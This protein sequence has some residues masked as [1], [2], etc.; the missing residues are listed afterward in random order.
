MQVTNNPQLRS[1]LSWISRKS[2]PRR[3]VGFS[4]PESEIESDEKSG[5]PISTFFVE[6]SSAKNF[7]MFSLK[8]NGLFWRAQRDI[9]CR[10]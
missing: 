5:Q 3:R 9:S 1:I 8:V 7:G 2:F 6:E 4:V 10:N